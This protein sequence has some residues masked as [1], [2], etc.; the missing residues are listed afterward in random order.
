MI[1]CR[2]TDDEA[3]AQQQIAADLSTVLG[4]MRAPEAPLQIAIVELESGK[5]ALELQRVSRLG[6]RI[7]TAC[8]TR[9]CRRLGD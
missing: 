1:E 4:Q 6:R 5:A 3:D 8:V 9:F 2:E 7:C